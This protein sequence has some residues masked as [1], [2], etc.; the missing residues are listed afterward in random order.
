MLILPTKR[1]PPK[2]KISTII[3]CCD[4]SD[5][6]RD[7]DR[8]ASSK[9]ARTATQKHQSERERVREDEEKQIGAFDF[10]RVLTL[11]RATYPN[12]FIMLNITYA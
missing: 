11:H 7:Y 3:A 2:N 8:R 5:A 12:I 6:K 1:C 4:A 10:V 9:R